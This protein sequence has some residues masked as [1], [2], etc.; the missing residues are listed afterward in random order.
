MGKG[1]EETLDNSLYNALK[2]PLNF[3]ILNKQLFA[4]FL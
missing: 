3:N 1:K 2:Q 4:F